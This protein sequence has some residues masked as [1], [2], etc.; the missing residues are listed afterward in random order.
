MH[1][2][3]DAA[4]FTAAAFFCGD[5]AVPNRVAIDNVGHASLRVVTRHGAEFG[6]AVNQLLVVPT[7]F[8]QIQREYPIFFR[9]DQDGS[10]QSVA[11]V[12][13]DRGENLI[14]DG[15]QWN[16]HYVPAVQRR[17]PF[18]IAVRPSDGEPII[19]VDLD[20]PRVGEGEGEPLFKPHG[21]NA[22]YL[23]HVADALLTIH[24]GLGAA[25]AMFAL[26]EE[27]GLIQPIELNVDLG[28]GLTYRIPNFFTVGAEQFA[29]LTGEALDRLNRSGFLPAAIF[30]R[31]SLGNIERLIELKNARRSA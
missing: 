1:G 17:G 21:G 15:H 19:H 6:D 30:V 9:K 12:G 3:T 24:E 22:P 5:A 23:D 28:D 29:A 11:L 14:L 4:A 16:A 31:S 18:F 2:K 25:P 7:E 27:L 13:F 10:F 20:D 26:F 8:E